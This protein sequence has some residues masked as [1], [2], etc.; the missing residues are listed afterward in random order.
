[1]AVCSDWFDLKYYIGMPQ[2]IPEAPQR[3][4]EGDIVAADG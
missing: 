4:T 2:T 3:H 1:M